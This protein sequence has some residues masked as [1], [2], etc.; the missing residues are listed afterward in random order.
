MGNN[1]L[2]VTEIK[3]S[4][5]AVVVITWITRLIFSV[6]VAKRGESKAS[7]KCDLGASA[8]APRRQLRPKRELG[9]Y[10]KK[11]QV[12]DKSYSTVF[13]FNF[14]NRSVVDSNRVTSSRNIRGSRVLK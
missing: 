9:K 8:G 7:T 11:L 12:A 2:V 13:P 3:V 4:T 5:C 1:I 10:T 14:A 6:F